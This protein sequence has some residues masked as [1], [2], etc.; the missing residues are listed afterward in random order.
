ME[1]QIMHRETGSVGV[2]IKQTI[3]LGLQTDNI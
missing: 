3:E 2:E 1:C